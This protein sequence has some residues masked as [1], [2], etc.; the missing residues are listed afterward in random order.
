[1]VNVAERIK[2]A[3]FA[4]SWTV[5]KLCGAIEVSEAGYKHMVEN[6]SWKLHNLSKI[7]EVLDMPLTALVS[8]EEPEIVSRPSGESEAYLQDHLKRLEE[9]FARLSAQL[10]TKDR[11]IDGLQRTADSLQRYVDTLLG[12]TPANE[13]ADK[14][15]KSFLKPATETGRVVEMYPA[16]KSES[17]KSA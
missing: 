1:M 7:A 2:K 13:K 16:E 4:K 17:K 12:S 15:A 6:N 9:N 11:Q 3:L 14:K 5:K 10:E 8:E